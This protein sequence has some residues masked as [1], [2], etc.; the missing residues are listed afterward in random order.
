MKTE[1][2]MSGL[3]RACNDYNGSWPWRDFI[4]CEHCGELHLLDLGP[5]REWVG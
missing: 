5:G 1:A 3:Y 2:D 4:A